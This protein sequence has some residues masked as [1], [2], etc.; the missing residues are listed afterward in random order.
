MNSL[1]TEL[2]NPDRGQV[3]VRLSLPVVPDLT[4]K[5]KPFR[6]LHPLRSFDPPRESVRLL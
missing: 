4:D 2:H 6:Q 5:R 3:C 1:L